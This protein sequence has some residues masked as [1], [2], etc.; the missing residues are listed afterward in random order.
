MFPFWVDLERTEAL[1]GEYY[2]FRDLKERTFWPDLST[3]GIPLQYYQAYTAL[4]TAYM[5][6]GQMEPSNEALEEARKFV[7]V[8]LGPITP[9]APAPSP[10]DL[11]AQ[12]VEPPAETAESA[13]AGG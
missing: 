13:G 5:M 9:A 3:N 11:P 7:E 12:P 8:A 1:L 6:L 10:S 2:T 4:A